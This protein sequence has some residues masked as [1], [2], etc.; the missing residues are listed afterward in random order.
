M[1]KNT[2]F[3]FNMNEGKRM[4]V[5]NVDWG[6]VAIWLC[7][8]VPV[9]AVFGLHHWCGR[10]EQQR[11]THFVGVQLDI[12]ILIIVLLI[13]VLLIKWIYIAFFG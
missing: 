7:V 12:A 5:K 3:N 6:I 2:R 8:I 13:L 11:N 9:L 4:I 10:K 1:R